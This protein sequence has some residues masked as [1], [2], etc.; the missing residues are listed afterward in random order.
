MQINAGD[1]DP[2]LLRPPASYLTLHK[3][4]MHAEISGTVTVGLQLKA[5]LEASLLGFLHA[6]VQLYF[7]AEFDLQ[8]AVSSLYGAVLP[9]EVAAT[10]ALV[11]YFERVAKGFNVP[12]GC[13]SPGCPTRLSAFMDVCPPDPFAIS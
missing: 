12:L 9:A 13:P 6:G 11:I 10:L 7:R 2:H 3:P 4:V 5:Q 8:P 1:L